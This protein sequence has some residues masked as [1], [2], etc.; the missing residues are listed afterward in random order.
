MASM[1]VQGLTH[2]RCATPNGLQRA[3]AQS[4]KV[5][6]AAFGHI[7]KAFCLPWLLAL[8][9]LGALGALLAK[10]ARGSLAQRLAAGLFTFEDAGALTLTHE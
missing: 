4:G 10:C 7:A 6:L 5:T 8:A 2:Y 9:M 1:S 3:I